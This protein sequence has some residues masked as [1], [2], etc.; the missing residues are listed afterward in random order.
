MKIDK[1][2]YKFYPILVFGDSSLVGFHKGTFYKYHIEHQLIEKICQLKLSL[3]ETLIHNNRLLSRLFRRVN[4]TSVKWGD[5]ILLAYNKTLFRLDLNKGTIHSIGTL[6]RGKRP[7]NM[8]HVENQNFSKGIYFGE[9]FNNKNKTPV[10]IYHLN[11]IG[12]IKIVFTFSK[13][14]INHVHSLIED[15]K[16]NCIWILTGDFGNAAAIWRAE[17]NF[18]IVTPIASGSQDYRAC[19]I[20]P[21]VQG[22]LYAT[23]S[24]LVNNS[25]RLLTNKNDKWISEKLFDVNGSVIYGFESDD[26]LFIS[27]TVES[28]GIYKSKLDSY[29]SR[30]KGNG[31][32]DYYSYVYKINKITFEYQIIYKQKKDI[33]PFVF[34]QFGALIFPNGYWTSRTIPVFHVATVKN[35]LRTVLLN[36]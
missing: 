11:E 7:L 13:G 16:N 9:Y 24:P 18:S 21:V 10:H 36:Y 30:K 31:I 25:V 28:N 12:D 27:T 3:K 19:I 23:D 22:M 4:F 1:N 6:N 33:F 29:I 34:F 2:I 17:D 20:S 35:D 5:D 32:K 15:K 26:Y 8:I 14:L